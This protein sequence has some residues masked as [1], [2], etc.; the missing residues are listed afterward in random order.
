MQNVK[1]SFENLRFMS[2]K[3][4]YEVK[5]NFTFYLNQRFVTESL[6]RHSLYAIIR[7]KTLFDIRLK[8]FYAINEKQSFRRN[9]FKIWDSF[10]L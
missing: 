4:W 9:K 6:C 5:K 1:K 10:H 8:E 3:D 7:K 2:T